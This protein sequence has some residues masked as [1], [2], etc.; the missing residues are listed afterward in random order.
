[1][2]KRL[3]KAAVAV[4]LSPVAVVADAVMLPDDATEDREFAPRTSTL[5][6]AAG[7]N[8]RRAVDL[9]EREEA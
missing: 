8:I 1:M 4:A 6:R 5:L 3:M 9:E 2:I 7:E